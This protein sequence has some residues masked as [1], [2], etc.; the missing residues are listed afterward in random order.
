MCVSLSSL[1]PLLFSLHLCL[2]SSLSFSLS[3]FLSLSFSLSLSPLSMWTCCQYTRRRFESTHEGVLGA[4]H[5]GRES[6]RE[7]RGRGREQASFQRVRFVFAPKTQVSPTI[8]TSVI[9]GA[10]TRVFP[11]FAL[12]GHSSPSLDSHN[13]L[14]PPQQTNTHNNTLTQP[15]HHT[16]TTTQWRKHR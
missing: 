3:L 7:E 11:N 4:T 1:I 14:T 2:S 13:Q 15:Q 12:L 8:C 10:A 6:E 5:G 9:P 16:T